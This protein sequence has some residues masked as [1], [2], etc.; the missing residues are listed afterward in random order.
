M[1]T[2]AAGNEGDIIQ[3]IGASTQD[4]TQGYFY[5]CVSDGEGEAK[6]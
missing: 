3:Y 5:Q 1:P 4:Y 6:D 2:P